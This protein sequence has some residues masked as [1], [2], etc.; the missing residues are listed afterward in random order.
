MTPKHDGGPAFP[1][2]DSG[3]TATRPGMSL[4]AYF[5]AHAPDEIPQWFKHKPLE[6][7]PP[8][9]PMIPFG[10]EHSV[11]H[12]REYLHDECTR[13]AYPNDEIFKEFVKRHRAYFAARH[14]YQIRDSAAR[15]IQWRCTYA[16]LM[17]EGFGQ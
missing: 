1:H 7:S 2:T 13:D 14:E 15:M 4:R 12:I 17:L 10:P 6:E 16:D 3:D 8:P 11:R 9:P 5:A